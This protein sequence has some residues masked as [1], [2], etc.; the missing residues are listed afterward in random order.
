MIRTLAFSFLIS[1][2][3]FSHGNNILQFEGRAYDAET[4]QFIYLEKHTITLDKEGKYASS[5]VQYLDD[6]GDVFAS[7]QVSFEANS[8]APSFTFIDHRTNSEISVQNKVESIKLTSKLG[9]I[10]T[11]ESVN[12][13]TTN[14]LVVDAGFDRF[15]YENW[16]T[17]LQNKDISFAFLA[18]SR[19]M[20][21][22]LDVKEKS[23]TTESVVYVVQPSN[24]FLSL[25]VDPIELTY[26]IESQRLTRFEGLTNIAKRKDGRVQG[27]N[28]IAVIQY[29]YF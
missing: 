21:V 10:E 12:I 23:R 16:E 25:L 6:N 11:T 20:L 28:Y 3:G 26:H 29:E 1:I 18:I 15:I 17:L 7:K 2:S 8:I 9:A 14:G 27:D 22:N 13:E 19:A 4:E 24:F 5:S